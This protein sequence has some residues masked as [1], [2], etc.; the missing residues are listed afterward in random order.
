MAEV[1]RVRL[2]P[3]GS[4]SVDERTQTVIVRDVECP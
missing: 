1:I 2:T 3:R 4:V